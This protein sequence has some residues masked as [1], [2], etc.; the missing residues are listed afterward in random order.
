MSFWI[1]LA[2]GLGIGLLLG[3]WAA[4]TMIGAA[5]REECDACCIERMQVC[6]NCKA[7]RAQYAV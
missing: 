3:W 6:K 4:S 2:V 5:R 1:L 7:G